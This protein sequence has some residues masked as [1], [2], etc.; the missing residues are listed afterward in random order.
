MKNKILREKSPEK[1][2]ADFKNKE[3]LT[4]EQVE[5]FQKYEALLSEWNKSVNLTSIQG[6]SE[7][8]G[9]HFSD[10]LALRKFLDVSK[11]KLLA[12]IGTGAG[13]P[14]LPIKIM[15][16]EVGMILIEVNKKKQRFLSTV[17]NALE[18]ENINVCDLDWRTFLRTTTSDVEC[19]LARASIL[20]PELCRM[21]K[22]GCAYK[23]SKLIYWASIDWESEEK[24]K[25]FVLE[26]FF[27]DL[28]RKKRKLVLMGRK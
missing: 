23:N 22:P 9:R 12:D 19:F 11:M 8:V 27:Y 17:I 15:F 2:W 21:F 26:E 5:K 3:N 14:G 13:F 28:K 10:S 6:L 7:T 24:V 4:D 18:L 1:V 20:P 16:P 25:E